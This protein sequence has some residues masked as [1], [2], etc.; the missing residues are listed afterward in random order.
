MKTIHAA[1]GALLLT[2]CQSL[3]QEEQLEYRTLMWKDAE[4]IQVKNP[5]TAALLNVLPGIGDIYNEQWG[6][7]CVDFLLW[8]PSVVWAVPQAAMTAKNINKKA[9]IAYYRANPVASRTSA[10]DTTVRSTGP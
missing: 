3:S 10:R 7:F 9:T 6:A 1:L 5:T 2:G 4:P 8:F